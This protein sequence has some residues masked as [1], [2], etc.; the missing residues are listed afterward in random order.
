[1]IDLNTIRNILIGIKSE[2]NLNSE[3][4]KAISSATFILGMLETM[5]VSVETEV[6]DFDYLK[7]EFYEDTK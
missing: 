7:K 1:M 5:M 6:K 3:E 4:K 2:H